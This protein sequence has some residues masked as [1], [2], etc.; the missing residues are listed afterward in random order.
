MPGILQSPFLDRI[1]GSNR[2]RDTLVAALADGRGVTAKVRW[3]SGRNGEEEGR[4]RWIHCTPLL[5]QSGSIG[6]WMVVLIEDEN[7][8]PQ[9]KF[10][11]PPPVDAHVRARKSELEMFNPPALPDTERRQ[12]SYNAQQRIARPETSNSAGNDSMDSFT[13]EPA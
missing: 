5:G 10:R 13:I 7:A 3:V 2:V 12:H 11:Q 9:R 8:T 4:P 6:V 1:G